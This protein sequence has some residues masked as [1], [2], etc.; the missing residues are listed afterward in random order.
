M[1]AR[2]VTC[3]LMNWTG[4]SLSFTSQN[5]ALSSGA[6]SAGKA[7]PP[8]CGDV[9][10]WVAEST[11]GSVTGSAT[12]QGASGGVTVTW[13]VPVAGSNSYTGTPTGSYVMTRVDGEKVG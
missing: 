11:D 3:S 9:T 2:S 13:D 10:V 7:P 6:Y 8:S 12:F 1:A 4:E 5:E